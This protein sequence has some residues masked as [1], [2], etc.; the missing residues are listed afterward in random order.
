MG[1]CI[2]DNPIIEANKDLE[3][4]WIINNFISICENDFNS[5]ICGTF[6]EIHTPGN[7][8]VIEKFKINKY[9]TDGYSTMYIPTHE[10]CAGRYEL[11]FVSINRKTKYLHYIKPFYVRYPSCNCE[12]IQ[13]YNFG[14]KC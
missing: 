9:Y 13:K 12:Y 14:F 5:D 2:E 11:W 8:N 4:A 10:L 3:I 6:I 7:E 1:N